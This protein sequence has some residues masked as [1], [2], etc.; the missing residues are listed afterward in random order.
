MCSLFS[1]DTIALMNK[2]QMS[3]CFEG[4]LYEEHPDLVPEHKKSQSPDRER[5]ID[6]YRAAKEAGIDESIL[7]KITQDGDG[8]PLLDLYSRAAD[9]IADKLAFRARCVE[10]GNAFEKKIGTDSDQFSVWN[11]A[12]F[13]TIDE[14]RDTATV[15][16][17]MK[18]RE[19]QYH[20]QRLDN[21]WRFH[22]PKNAR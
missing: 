13:G 9:S 10:I 8:T 20:F 22:I 21:Q 15:K 19:T 7:H 1:P 4:Y 16:V 14:N 12:T 3:Y 18:G 2:T 6:V 17:S 5:K 11:N